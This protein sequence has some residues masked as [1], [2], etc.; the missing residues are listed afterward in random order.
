M[1]GLKN[2]LPKIRNTSALKK[3]YFASKA[4]RKWPIAMRIAPMM[5]ASLLPR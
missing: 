1:F 2:P 4:I 3:M 5:T